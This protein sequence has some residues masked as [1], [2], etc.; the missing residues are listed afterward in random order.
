MAVEGI[1]GPSYA[2]DIAVDSI[3]FTPGRCKIKGPS[4]EEIQANSHLGRGKG[5]YK[6]SSLSAERDRDLAFGQIRKGDANDFKKVKED[7]GKLH[8]KRQKA[9]VLHYSAE[10][11]T[12]FKPNCFPPPLSGRDCE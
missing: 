1:R 11:T 5:Y 7:V 3:K 8:W 2:G 10:E 9:A 4:E 6:L 12:V